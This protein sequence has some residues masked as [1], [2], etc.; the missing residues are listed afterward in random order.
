[1]KENDIFKQKLIR[2]LD[3]NSKTYLSTHITLF[4]I[5]S[6]SNEE[7]KCGQFLFTLHGTNSGIQLIICQQGSQPI[8][9][10]T[11]FET[12]KWNIKNQLFVNFTDPNNNQWLLQF[13][14]IKSI[15]F[16]SSCFYC[17][18][19]CKK[20]NE[21]L[22]EDIIHKDGHLLSNGDILKL[23]YYIFPVKEFPFV[24]DPIFSCENQKVL[25]SKEKIPQFILDGLKNITVG[26]IRII[27]VP[28]NYPK[29]EKFPN[30]QL[31]IYLQIHHAKFKDD[32]S[33]ISE[34]SD[35]D[36]PIK[37]LKSN[38]TQN[39]EEIDNPK[40]NHNNFPEINEEIISQ[41][42]LQLEHN[43]FTKLDLFSSNI[44][45]D[46]IVQGVSS[47]VYQLK[48]KNIELSNLKNESEHLKKK[49][50]TTITQ[51]NIEVLQKEL[52]ELKILKVQNERK[53]KEY[54][55]KIQFLQNQNEL[56]QKNS[57]NKVKLLIKSL[58]SNVY[59]DISTQIED[60]QTLI[61]S[62]VSNMLYQL[63]R[64]HSFSVLDDINNNGL[65]K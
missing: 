11:I 56:D 1:M 26:T 41:R 59:S 33:S 20:P 55:E 3:S 51:K 21:F 9:N 52:D 47:M 43:I 24:T 62:D 57:Q 25:F 63:F 4:R 46:P 42:L 16:A 48:Q 65:F 13:P 53:L 32:K 8:I 40:D 50:T 17:C 60:N 15:A 30:S 36:I 37:I 61:G 7:E 29:D 12:F 44:D 34:V 49:P 54:T 35:H 28:P 5:H 27:F 22:T 31:I 39:I 10:F 6:P 58:M 23:S 18:H 19:F 14:N 64:K 2:K 45:Q 38:E